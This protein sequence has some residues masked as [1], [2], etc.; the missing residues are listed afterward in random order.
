LLLLF[1]KSKQVFKLSIENLSKG[2]FT[3][4]PTPYNLEDWEVG[5]NTVV[6]KLLNL[7]EGQTVTCTSVDKSVPE[8][9][10][11]SVSPAS[12]EDYEILVNN[13]IKIATL[14]LET[15]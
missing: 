9:Q 7:E 11:V 3:I 14:D 1:Q 10:S 13:I 2:V 5:V 6:A 4:N 8:A 12:E 15:G